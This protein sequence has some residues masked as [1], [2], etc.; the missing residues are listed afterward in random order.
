MILDMD[1]FKGIN[2]SYGH[3][4]GDNVLIQAAK[5]LKSVFR[6]DD[7]LGRIGGDEFVIFMKDIDSRGKVEERAVQVC[8]RFSSLFDPSLDVT[9]SIG[10]AMYP[11]HGTDNRELYQNADKALYQAK[12][13]GKNMYMVYDTLNSGNRVSDKTLQISKNTSLRERIR[14]N[15]Q[16]EQLLFL[17]NH[18]VLSGLSNRNAYVSFLNELEKRSCSL[19]GLRSAISMT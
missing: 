4:F 11:D 18:D 1:N 19:W 10:I 6:S 7:V 9:C 8:E 13:F 14:Y 3:H 12:R 15:E 5:T 16:K 2:E 17:S